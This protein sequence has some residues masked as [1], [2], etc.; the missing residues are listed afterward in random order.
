MKTFAIFNPTYPTE[1]VVDT[2]VECDQC[3][4]G[5]PKKLYIT[6]GEIIVNTS[7]IDWIQAQKVKHSPHAGLALSFVYNPLSET[8]LSSG[9]SS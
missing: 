2:S 6:R 9:N 1:I 3:I 5:R 8:K 4:L 7:K